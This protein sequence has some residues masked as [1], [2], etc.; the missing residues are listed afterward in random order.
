M[1]KLQSTNQG[2]RTIREQLKKVAI[3]MLKRDSSSVTLRIII[4]RNGIQAPDLQIT[5]LLS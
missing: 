4:C 3:I 1:G 5:R 2:I